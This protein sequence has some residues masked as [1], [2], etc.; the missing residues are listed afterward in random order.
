MILVFCF[1]VDRNRNS[2]S[3]RRW[4]FSP[5]HGGIVFGQKMVSVPFVI[6]VANCHFRDFGVSLVAL[7]DLFF[8]KFPIFRHFFFKIICFQFLNFVFVLACSNSK[9]IYID[10]IMI[11]MCKNFV[12]VVLYASEITLKILF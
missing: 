5:V 12:G 1:A 10:G 7:I 11:S 9:C 6:G 8:N 2:V 3:F 4:G